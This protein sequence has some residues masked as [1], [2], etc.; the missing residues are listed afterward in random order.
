MVFGKFGG[1]SGGRLANC[2]E[3][4]SLAQHMGYVTGMGGYRLQ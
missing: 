3:G 2:L 4:T 1:A